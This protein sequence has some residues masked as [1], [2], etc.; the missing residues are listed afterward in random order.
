[1]PPMPT[2]LLVAPAGH[3]KTHHAVERIRALRAAEPLAPVLVLLPNRVRVIEFRDRLAAAGGALG[4]E[5]LT[6]H[7][8]YADLL[9]RAGRPSACLAETAQ[10]HLLRAMVDRL[11]D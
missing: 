1:M 9:A 6:F 5:L 3:G 8:L 2:R 11:C 4:V 10:V 7:N